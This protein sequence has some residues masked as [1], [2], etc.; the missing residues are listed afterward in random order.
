MLNRFRWVVAVSVVGMSD[1]LIVGVLLAVVFMAIGGALLVVAQKEIALGTA[2]A[3][4]T[5]IGAAGTFL[6]G[7]WLSGM[8]APWALASAWSSSLPEWPR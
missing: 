1:Q 3:V 8:P 4:W 7:I 2:Y 5:E 6:V